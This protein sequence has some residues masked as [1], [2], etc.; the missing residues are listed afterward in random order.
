MTDTSPPT[1]DSGLWRDLATL[2]RYAWLPAATIVIT[3]VA[4]LLIGALR[5]ATNE[6]RFRENVVVNALP[7]L[8][9]PPVLPSP[10]DYAKLA[11][12]DAV[13]QRVAQEH[14]L[15]AAALRSRLTATA[16]FNAPE[17]DFSVTGSRALAIARSW[18][19]AFADAA[20][21]QQSADLERSLTAPYTRQLDEAR[22]LLQH[23]AAGAKASPVDPVAQQQLVAAEANYATASELSQSY[24]V[25]ARTMQATSFGVVGPH[26]QSAGVGST[27]GRAG[28]ALAI[29]LLAGVIGALAL[30]A[31]SRRG[32]LDPAADSP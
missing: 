6:A 14:G 32:R 21:G 15:A 17:I 3:L 16:H 4:A 29:G 1:R 20:A 11:T 10:F 9:G 19:Q 2:R 7:P 5:P 31:V 13:V 28:A 18:R 26:Q 24:E 27:A 8:F 30:S 22:S 12:S 25:V 23:A